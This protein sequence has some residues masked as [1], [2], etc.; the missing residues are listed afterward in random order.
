MKKFAI[1]LLTLAVLSLALAAAPVVTAVYAAPDNDPP[2]PP[3]GKKKRSSEVRPGGQETA[4]ANGRAAFCHDLA[5]GTTTPA[6]SCS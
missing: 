5:I 4:F 6:R 1:R 3:Q 2:P